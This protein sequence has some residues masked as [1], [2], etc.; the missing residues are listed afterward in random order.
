VALNWE[1]RKPTQ[2]RPPEAVHPGRGG[3][4]RGLEGEGLAREMLKPVW[5]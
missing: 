1:V 5:E 3:L 2:L 4:P